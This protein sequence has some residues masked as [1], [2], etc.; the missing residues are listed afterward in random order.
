MSLGEDLKSPC[1]YKN[2]GLQKGASDAEIKTAYKRMA[3]KYHPDK[4]KENRAIAEENF[5]KVAEAYDVLSDRQKREVYDTYGKRGLENGG[6]GMGG[7]FGHGGGHYQVNPE[8]IFRQFFGGHDDFGGG[9]PF[10]GF[11]GHPRMHQRKRPAPPR[12]PSG[13]DIVPKDTP[14]LVHS[15]SN[16]QEY[17]G[18]SGKLVGYD[19][20][21]LRYKVSFGETEDDKTISIKSDNF[22][23]LVENV[24]LRDIQSQPKLNNCLGSI[25]G[26][27]DTRYHVRLNGNSACVGVPLA[28]LILPAETRVHIHSLASAPQYNGQTGRVITHLVEEN[29]Y[30]VEINGG[31]QLKLKTDNISL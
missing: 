11:G 29:R 25:I 6:C 24:K 16:A 19:E 2:L 31:R 8:D 28:N 12:Y 15:L 27:S 18:M 30:L 13:P 10:D 1:Y 17:N 9:F 7:G 22:I 14:V 26:L 3:L 23:L 20:T 21:K 4:N 5:K